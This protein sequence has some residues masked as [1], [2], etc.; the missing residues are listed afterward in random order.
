MDWDQPSKR[1]CELMQLGAR[2]IIDSPEDRLDRI[3]KATLTPEYMRAIASD[4][5]LAEAVRRSNRSNRL[6]WAAANIS[7]PGEPVPPNLGP[8]SLTIARHL[9]RRGLDEST[10]VDAYRVGQNVA[11][12]AWMQIAFALTSDPDELRELLD[13]S[14]ASIGSFIDATI[15]GI[16]HQMRLERDELTRGT[17]AEQRETVALILDGAPITPQHAENRLGYR[18]G[19]SH[20]AAVIWGDESTTTSS[21]LDRAADALAH[22][23]DGRRSLSVLAGAATRWVW[24]PGADGPD[25][26]GVAAAISQLPGVRIAVG[27][28]AA[29]IDGFRRSH[30]DA[31]TTQRTVVRLGSTQ[32]VV[33][34]TDVELI[35][36]VTAD[37][38]RADRFIKHTLGEFESADAELQ[39]TVL[40]FIHEQCNASR[41]AASLF[42]HRNTLL[43]RLARADELLPKP[44]K[45]SSVH[46][47]V[48]LE[49]LRWRGAA[50]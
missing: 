38:E 42:T 7:H 9:V 35:A 27:P 49:A 1:V 43:R 8:E 25:L 2:M 21:D 33:G 30:F 22:N 10:A 36:L 15:A 47:A 28:T 26:T 32:R 20:T 5:V 39:R 6:H 50:R 3:N 11:W 17:H 40:T 41:A 46:V 45:E 13:V 18:L 34:F 44:L 16:Y 19:Q 4:P 24:V 29:G 12:R 37:P 23:A 31:I 14:A 48:A